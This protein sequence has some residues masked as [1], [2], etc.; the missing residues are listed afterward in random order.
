MQKTSL[1]CSSIILVLALTGCAAKTR[2]YHDAGCDGVIDTSIPSTISHKGG[3]LFYAEGDTCFVD[4][5]F[6]KVSTVLSSGAAHSSQ[7]DFLALSPDAQ[8][9]YFY[10]LTIDNHK[11]IKNGFIIKKFSLLKGGPEIPLQQFYTTKEIFGVSSQSIDKTHLGLSYEKSSL[12]L[13]TENGSIKEA[14]FPA[15]T[16]L[17]AFPEAPKVSFPYDAVE[18]LAMNKEGSKFAFLYVIGQREEGHRVELHLV[19]LDTAT[20]KAT[21]VHTGSFMIQADY[22]GDIH[23][24]C[25]AYDWPE[26]APKDTGYIYESCNEQDRGRTKIFEYN[27]STGAKTQLPLKRGFIFEV[28][29]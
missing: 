26:G 17:P 4:G 13:D 20:Q 21:E 22:M 12:I 8:T 28:R 25:L 16:P 23:D 9:V 15:P 1:L 7:R 3:M 24:Y 10:E 5:T 27:E 11:D 19:L 2:D 6:K 14:S 29:D 18:R